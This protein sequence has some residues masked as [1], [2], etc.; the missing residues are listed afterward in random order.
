LPRSIS[1]PTFCIP[2]RICFTPHF[3]GVILLR[4][5]PKPNKIKL[6]LA[7]SIAAAGIWLTTVIVLKTHRSNGPVEILRQLPKNIDISLQKI[8]YTEIKDGVK[9]WSLVA[10]KVEYDR[11]RTC[12]YFRNVK[13]DL[14]SNGKDEGKITLTA[15]RAVYHDKTGDI[16]AEGNVVASNETGMRFETGHLSYQPSRFMIST[17]DHVRFIDGKL[18]VE[19]TG[20]ELMIKAKKC[21]VLKNV[22]AIVGAGAK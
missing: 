14:F 8:H 18:T 6:V 9:K 4:D 19:G 22:T 10:E 2:P 13:V 7:L 1:V 11:D 20:M 12:S 3:Y 16:E 15:D 17:G 21:R 5:M